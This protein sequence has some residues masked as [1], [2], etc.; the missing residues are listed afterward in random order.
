MSSPLF[1]TVKKVFSGENWAFSEVPG[2]EVV[3]AGFEAHHSR[4][5]LHVQA[6][7]ELTAVSVVSESST[8]TGSDP[9]RRERIAELLMRINQSLTVGNFELNWETGQVLYRATN[10]F[11]GETGDPRIIRGLIHTTIMEMDRLTPLLSAIVRAEGG[12]LA[13]LD[14]G[15]MVRR[16]E[17]EA[18]AEPESGS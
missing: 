12:E 9:A 18:A 16:S 17:E 6:F 4:I 15:G 2:R 5:E 8:T 14:I 13:G 11:S 7:P 1:E 10:L 3:Q